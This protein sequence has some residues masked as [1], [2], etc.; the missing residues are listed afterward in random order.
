M[1]NLDDEFK[2]KYIKKLINEQDVENRIASL[3]QE[4]SKYYD[5]EDVVVVCVLKG[6]MYFYINLCSNIT[7]NVVEDFI[8]V[9]SYNGTEREDVKTVTLPTMDVNN[10]NVLIVEDIVDSGYTLEYL[11]KYYKEAGAKDVKTAVLLDK[12]SRREV[13]VTADFIGFEVPDEF[14]VGSG[15][16]FDEYFRNLNYIGYIPNELISDFKNEFKEKD[17]IRY[18]K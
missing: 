15:L 11:I 3:G 12:P 4:I 9:K 1:V 13:D 14:I 18:L 17:Y 2:N 10:R 16:D 6:A 8:R 7:V 5:G